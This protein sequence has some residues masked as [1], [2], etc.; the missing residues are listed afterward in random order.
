MEGLILIYFSRTKK[1][2]NEKCFRKGGAV[3]KEKKEEGAT[4]NRYL[5]KIIL[6][7]RPGSI[8]DG[9]YFGVVDVYAVLDAF[10]VSCPARSNAIKKLL[11]P[12]D[13]GYKGKLTDL[14][15][16]IDSSIRAFEMQKA[17][18]FMALQETPQEE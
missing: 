1:F 17:R 6:K 11:C 10:G 3:P 9:I 4:G 15:E 14:G 5:K 8:G 7:G 18:R 13:R 2:I 12:G 16:A